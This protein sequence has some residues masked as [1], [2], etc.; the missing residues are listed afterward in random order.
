MAGICHGTGRTE[1][2]ARSLTPSGSIHQS[3]QE[4]LHKEAA[5]LRQIETAEA[6]L[7]GSQRHFIGKPGLKATLA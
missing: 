1:K 6:K 5:K 2:A 4:G 3:G 7:R